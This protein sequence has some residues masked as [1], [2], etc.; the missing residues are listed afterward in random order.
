M[1]DTLVLLTSYFNL[2]NGRRQDTAD[3]F[4]VDA[5]LPSRTSPDGTA[6]LYILTESSTGGHMG[7]RV[8]RLVADTI[9][10]EYSAHGDEPPAA[11]LKAA[12]RTAHEEALR[13]FDGHVSVGSSV[14]AVEHTDVYL[15]QVAP[16]QVYVLHE[17]SLHSISAT[18]GGATPFAH[19]VG[20]TTGP[21][22]SVF[23]DEIAPG[24][25]L[26][27]CSSW[28]HRTADPD[29]LRECF[30]AG[31]ADDISECILD[32]GKQH[33]VRDAQVIVIEAALASELDGQAQ[34]EPQGFME[35]VDMAVQALA[36]VGRMFV[37]ELRGQPREAARNGR[38]AS[39]MPT[40]PPEAASTRSPAGTGFA[41]QATAETAQVSS[42][43]TRSRE[44]WNPD[45]TAAW[46]LD[47]LRGSGPATGREHSTEKLSGVTPD[48]PMNRDNWEGETEAEPPLSAYLPESN[49]NPDVEQIDENYGDASPAASEQRGF[50]EL[51]E[52]NSRIQ[53]DP[54]IG[55]AIPPVQTFPDTSTEPS[56]IYSTSRDIQSVN[57]RP[58]RFGGISRPVK[59]Q[60]SSTPVLRPGLSDVDLRKPVSRPAPPAVV[61][62][63]A[64]VLLLVAVLAAWYVLK[65]H[66]HS[67]VASNP[68]PARFD[69]NIRLALASASTST[70]DAYLTKAREDI[71]L[72][73]QSGDTVADLRRLQSKLMT[74][75]NTI[76]HISVEGA[77]VLIAKFQQATELAVSPDTIYVLDAA[78]K[79]VFSVPPNT[80]SSPTEIIQSG[81]QNSGFTF[82]TPAHIATSGSTALAFDG[83]TLV[84][85]TGGTKSATSLSPPSP[86][87]R[88]VA[89][90]N[91]GPD[92]YLLD[93]AGNQVW[94]YPNAVQ[95]YNPVAGGF[96]S[97]NTTSVTNLES[98]ALDDKDMF[99]LKATGQILKFDTQQANSQPFNMMLR[100]PFKNAD[101][102]FTDVGLN[103]LWVAD[104]GNA[105]IVQLDKTGKYIRSYAAAAGT[106]MDLSQVKGIAVPPNGKTLYV[107]TT[108]ALYSF[109]VTP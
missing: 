106:G 54:D 9:A 14:I 100:T 81:E 60:T 57:R 90:A 5:S 8:R 15:A 41:E 26:A 105:R 45:E 84:R 76:Y 31:T 67:G 25:V 89:M 42:E 109:P 24:D 36:S 102:I 98:F 10:W 68:F 3:T 75:T 71:V 78:K 33:D 74:A 83:Q 21:Q 103:Y 49:T 30:G 35:Q 94:R 51:D 69:R 7:P 82:S 56:R 38:D 96:F 19:A 43:P 93:A 23:R 73:R 28:F 20:A 55:D 101:D 17:G 62:L 63:S 87:E 37:S 2:A 40:P 22:I 86:N 72:S 1:D 18:V 107:L 52:V 11:R 4:R 44:E 13:E 39:K 97:P 95:G 92:I 77:P 99:I 53:N 108:G 27:L 70:Q 48:V 6:A 80:N 32:L 16:A 12:L 64:A 29:E 61:W 34:L 88:I 104:P 66:S 65:K 59:D 50:S 58:R 91:F 47:E 85:Y 79:G 46:D